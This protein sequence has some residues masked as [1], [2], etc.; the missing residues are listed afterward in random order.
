MFAK[1]TTVVAASSES[2]EPSLAKRILVGKI[3]ILCLLFLPL[4]LHWRGENLTPRG[5][6]APSCPAWI[7]YRGSTKNMTASYITVKGLGGVAS[8][9]RESEKS[10]SRKPSLEH[11]EFSIQL[12]CIPRMP[13]RYR[14]VWWRHV[15]SA[16]FLVTLSP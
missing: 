11:S 2:S 14:G 13:A 10:S 6:H 12:K 8:I 1:P 16:G 9:H 3:V 15:C 7:Y 5:E 4:G